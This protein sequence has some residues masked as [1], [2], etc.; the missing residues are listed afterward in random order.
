M[1]KDQEL[2]SLNHKVSVLEAD[3]DK[4]ESKLADAKVAKDEEETNRSANENLNRKIA[5]L[6]SELDTAEKNLRDTTDKCVAVLG[7]IDFQPDERGLVWYRLRQVDVKAEH[8][9][10]QVQRIEAERDSWEKKFVPCVRSVVPR[11]NC[12]PSSGTKS[13][14]RST[15]RPSASSKRLLRRWR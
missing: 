2:A 15:S 8:F 3:L 11:A 9:E 14:R 12:Q 13:R 4:A 6:E 5:L 1:T 7:H 10:R